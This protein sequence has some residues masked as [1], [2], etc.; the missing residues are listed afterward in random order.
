MKSAG[1][2]AKQPE[3]H[4]I[5]YLLAYFLTTFTHP[6]FGKLGMKTVTI[7]PKTVARKWWIID[8]KEKVMG[9]LASEA[10]RLLMGKHRKTYSPSHDQG[11]FVVVINANNVALTGNKRQDL[12]YF[13]HS[14]YPGGWRELS[15]A[16]AQTNRPGY[17]LRHA[18]LGML[19]N[20]SLGWKMAKKLHIYGGYRHPHAAQK[21][22]PVVL[23]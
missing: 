8:A 2:A 7:N 13:R 19:P 23:R 1:L 18:I 12:R 15:V 16:Q 22:E 20:N 11:D 6:F 3:I 9:R 4:K 14:M 10:A 21:P 5:A 17:P